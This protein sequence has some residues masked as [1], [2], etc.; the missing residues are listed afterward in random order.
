MTDPNYEKRNQLEMERIKID[1]EC[2]K[3]FDATGEFPH[4]WRDAAHQ[5][6]DDEIKNLDR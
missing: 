4:E 2:E 6:I 1:N 3:H 5:E